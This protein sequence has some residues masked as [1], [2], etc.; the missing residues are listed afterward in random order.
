MTCDRQAP[1]RTG[2]PR[3]ARKAVGILAGS[4]LPH[5]KPAVLL[6]STLVLSTL[7]GCDLFGADCGPFPDTRESVAVGAT[8]DAPQAA[9]VVVAF[10]PTDAFPVWS[11][12]NVR[13]VESAEGITRLDG[14]VRRQAPGEPLAA[15]LAVRADTVFI[16]VDAARLI[17]PACSP[18]EYEPGLDV[19]LS[20]PE[21]TSIWSIVVVDPRRAPRFQTVSTEGAAP[22]PLLSA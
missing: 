1:D 15:R 5:M 10:V 17:R 19:T 12:I 21:G 20:L 7:S 11:G 22:R 4:R 13:A 9:S 2:L 16:T 3:I 6:L 18:A 14:V 8:T